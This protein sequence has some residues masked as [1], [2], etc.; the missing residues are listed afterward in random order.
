MKAGGL[1]DELASSLTYSSERR[2]GS[3][4]P[5]EMKGG[6]PLLASKILRVASSAGF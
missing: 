1:L 2:E 6:D 5:R 4:V 3:K